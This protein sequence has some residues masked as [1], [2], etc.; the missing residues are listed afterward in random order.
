MRM[1]VG[2]S[3]VLS[4][5]VASPSAK[6]PADLADHL[7]KSLVRIHMTGPRVQWGSCTAF[8]INK[9][10]GWGITAEHCIVTERGFEYRVV[11]DSFRPLAV[12]A[13]SS[14]T[15]PPNAYDDL[16]LLEG[17]IFRE[18]PALIALTIPSVLGEEVFA[19]GYA[20][21]EDVPFFF[22]SYIARVRPNWFSM[23]IA[24]S[25]LMGMSGAPVAN[26]DGLVIGVV[27][28]GT[29]ANTYITGSWHFQELYTAIL[30]EEELKEEA[31]KLLQEEAKE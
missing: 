5:L 24:G 21:G 16:A 7:R 2:V 14:R 1:L 28:R 23:E 18:V 11:D 6:R 27:T 30:L 13:R 26:K 15:V 31:K 22:Q 29:H 19:Y 17:D 8:A 9:D 4:L 25:V 20:G 10:R 12:V 3:L